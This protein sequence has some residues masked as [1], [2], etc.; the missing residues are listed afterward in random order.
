MYTNGAFDIL[1]IFEYDEYPLIGAEMSQNIY[2][3]VRFKRMVFL[4]LVLSFL[5][6]GR[7]CPA[8]EIQETN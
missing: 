4:L 1:L 7:S 2:P 3:V 6:D 8:S 5:F